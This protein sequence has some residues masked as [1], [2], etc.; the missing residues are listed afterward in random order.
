MCSL[1][2]SYRCNYPSHSQ[3]ERRKDAENLLKRVKVEQ[4]ASRRKQLAAA[5]EEADANGNDE[6]AQRLLMEMNKLLKK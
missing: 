4:I 6:E 3:E 1:E 5:I 2:S